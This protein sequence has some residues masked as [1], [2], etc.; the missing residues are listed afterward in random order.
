[1]LAERDGG[2][3]GAVVLLDEF[4]ARRIDDTRR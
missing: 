1:M 2:Q 3:A 4:G